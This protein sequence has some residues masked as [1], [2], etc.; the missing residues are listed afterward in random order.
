MRQE[1][2]QWQ[3][4]AIITAA[5]R[6][7]SYFH[8]LIGIPLLNLLTLISHNRRSLIL[9]VLPYIN[10]PVSHSF[11]HL[12][13]ASSH[14]ILISFHNM[15]NSSTFQCKPILFYTFI[16]TI[17]LSLPY[18]TSSTV[19]DRREPASLRKQSTGGASGEEASSS[20]FLRHS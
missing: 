2:F 5:P 1:L 11:I 18:R 9:C 14:T 20:K 3:Q 7:T 16:F 13:I 10:S 12:H 15:T 17:S 19:S 4:S 8:F 6:Y